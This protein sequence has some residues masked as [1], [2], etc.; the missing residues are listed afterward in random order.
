MEA[1]TSTKIRLSKYGPFFSVGEEGGGGGGIYR[2]TLRYIH[3]AHVIADITWPGVPYTRS[4]ITSPVNTFLMQY[5]EIH[6]LTGNAL[7]VSKD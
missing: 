3:S 4:G 1:L 6:I 2:D 7:R 5:L